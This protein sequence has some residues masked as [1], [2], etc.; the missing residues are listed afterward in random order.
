M[1]NEFIAFSYFPALKRSTRETC[2]TCYADA[3]VIKVRTNGTVINR[4]AY[5]WWNGTSPPGRQIVYGPMIR[6]QPQTSGH[7]VMFRSS[8]P[9]LCTKH[10]LYAPV[11][12]IRRTRQHLAAK[13]FL[14]QNVV[15]VSQ[16][17][18]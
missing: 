17:L 16:W 3:M 18:L 6:I 4:P 14:P 7:G 12:G 11:Y 10:R 13:E 9:F 15:E 5:G 1:S 8:H 2:P